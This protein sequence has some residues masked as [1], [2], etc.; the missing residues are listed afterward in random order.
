M[1]EYP[2]GCKLTYDPLKVGGV[3]VCVEMK[4]VAVMLTLSVSLSCCWELAVAQDGG[5]APSPLPLTLHETCR[6]IGAV[7]QSGN[8]SCAECAASS[9]PAEDGKF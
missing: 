2:R 4:V 6:E 5:A 7:F 8:L 9:E 3:C 1:T